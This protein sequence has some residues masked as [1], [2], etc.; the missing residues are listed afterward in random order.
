M[1]DDET[2]NQ[3]IARHEEEF[4]L[5]MVSTRTGATQTDMIAASLPVATGV[6]F[7]FTH[8]ASGRPHVG[9]V[10][11]HFCRLWAACPKAPSLYRGVGGTGGLRGSRA[12]ATDYSP[13]MLGTGMKFRW[14]PF[15][16]IWIQ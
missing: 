13:V 5:F 8:R 4:D 1:P 11:C 2:V 3:M 14:R 12:W 6:L 9:L 10:R 15:C 7:L 16:A